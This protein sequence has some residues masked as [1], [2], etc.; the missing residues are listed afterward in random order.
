METFEGVLSRCDLLYISIRVGST[1]VGRANRH[2]ANAKAI[3]R[4]GIRNGQ[5]VIEAKVIGTINGRF[6][7]VQGEV[8]LTQA[9]I[10][11]GECCGS[12]VAVFR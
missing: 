9:K 5:R 2:A 10:E 8:V 6:G 3:M 4:E 7:L 11:G 12:E 1:E